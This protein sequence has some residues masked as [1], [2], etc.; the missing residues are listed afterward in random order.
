MEETLEPLQ[1]SYDSLEPYI[2]QETMKIHHDKHHQNYF[3]K[4]KLALEKYPDLKNK[5][6][7]ELIANLNDIPEQ[8][9]TTV[10]NNGGG[11]A[12]HKLFWT[13]LKKDTELKGEIKEA[14]NS[15]FKNFNEFKSKFSEAAASI[16]GSGYA[17]LVVNEQGDLEIITTPNQDSPLTQNKTP[18]LVIDIWEHSYY[19]KYQN[20]RQEYIQSFFNIINWDKVNEYFVNAKSKLN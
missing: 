12:N 4:L 7:E 8:I 11:H 13:I 20:K 5:T 9:Q 3:D 14:I 15:D 19:L 2:D 1:Y 16:F 18:I 10:K 17:W 6:A